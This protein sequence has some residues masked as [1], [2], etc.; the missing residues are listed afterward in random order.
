MI[1]R[2][3]MPALAL[4]CSVTVAGGGVERWDPRKRR[5]WRFPLV[6]VVRAAMGAVVA[7]ARS[8]VAIDQRL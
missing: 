5:G 4:P 1:R 3:A 6:A 7:G 2:S 8:Y